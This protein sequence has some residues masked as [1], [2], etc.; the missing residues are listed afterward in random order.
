MPVDFKALKKL[1][2]LQPS[3]AARTIGDA[4][5]LLVL[6]QLREGSE[7][8]DYVTARTDIVSGM[9]TAEINGRDLRRLEADPAVHSVAISRR[10]PGI[11]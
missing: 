1:E 2:S 6:V 11:D 7:K 10:M 3:E 4:D 5:R 8:P 9:F